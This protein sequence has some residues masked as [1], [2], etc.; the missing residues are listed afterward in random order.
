VRIKNIKLKNFRNYAELDVSFPSGINILYGNNAQGKTNLL[1]SVYLAA[2]GRP[3]RGKDADMV[4]LGEASGCCKVTAE[5]SFGGYCVEISL[6]R[7]KK[8]VSVNGV[9][10]LKMGEMLGGINAVFFNPDELKMI[11]DAPELRRRFLDVDISQ[12]NKPYF[13][14]LQKYGDTLLHRN[15]ILKNQNKGYHEML[16]VYDEQLVKSGSYIISERRKF[17]Q[18][19]SQKTK[20]LHKYISQSEEIEIFYQTFTDET[21]LKK[22]QELYL[23]ELHRTREKDLRLCYTSTGPHRDDIKINI[24][25]LDVRVYGSQGQQRTAALSLK[26]SE[27]DFFKSVSGEPPVLLLDDVLSELDEGRKKRLADTIKDVQ[28]FIATAENNFTDFKGDVF[29]VKE[30]KIVLS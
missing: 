17:L 10:L 21:D 9:P 1:E 26:L 27:L 2:V 16:P 8:K 29:T 22:T 30:G 7:N 12:I 5:K 3:L 4:K 20:E 23:S 28:T 24:N 19:I 18:S 14:A 25:N 13:Y 15:N 6:F 11:K